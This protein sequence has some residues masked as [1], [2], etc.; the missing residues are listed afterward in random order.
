MFIF[1]IKYKNYCKTFSKTQLLNKIFDSIFCNKKFAEY[2]NTEQLKNISCKL[3]NY[4]F[5]RFMYLQYVTM[6]LCKL[7]TFVFYKVRVHTSGV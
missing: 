7:F 4:D 5:P 6:L 3:K 2:G 1:G